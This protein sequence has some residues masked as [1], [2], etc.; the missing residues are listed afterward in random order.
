MAREVQVQWR[1]LWLA[2]IGAD[3]VEIVLF[4]ILLVNAVAL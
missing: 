3:E 2:A 4:C 1:Q